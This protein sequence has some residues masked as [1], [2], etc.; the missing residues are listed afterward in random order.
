M[1]RVRKELE[2]LQGRVEKGELNAAAR[3]LGR[4]HGGRY[5]AWEL[6]QGK[7][8]YF[9]HPTHFP[10]EQA[11]EGKY[12]IQTEEPHLT[13]VQAVEAYKQLNDVERGFA[14]L[15]GLLEVRSVYHRA[16]ARVQGHVFVAALA[17]LLDRALEKK[18][19][20][21]GSSLSSPCAW[22]AGKRALHGA[23]FGT[24]SAS[25]VISRGSA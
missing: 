13:V 10:R 5:F 14:H 1:E 18:L 11:L 22:R 17:F 8:L 2:A 4:H 20:A 9:S 3:I 7:F 23:A 24:A 6:R 19:R 16:E 21:A 25:C 15:N 12:V